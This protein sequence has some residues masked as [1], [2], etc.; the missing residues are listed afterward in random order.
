MQK[1]SIT[2]TSIVFD[3]AYQPAT[4]FLGLAPFLRMSIA[5]T[6]FTRLAEEMLAKA[7]CY[8]DDAELWMNLSTVMMCLKQQKVGLVIQEQAL[9]MQRVFRLPAARQPA[10]LRLLMLMVPGDLSANMPLDCLL[11][12][13]DV[14][15]LY[16]FITP[17]KPLAWPV[18][19]HDVV[20]VGI[21]AADETRATLAELERALAG[22]PKPIINAPQD[23]PAS[24]RYAASMLLQH[25]PG[26]TI[27][28]A[29]PIGRTTL[30]RIAAGEMRLKDSVEGHDF[31]IILRPIGSHGGRGLAKIDQCSAIGAYL[32]EVPAK[33]YFISRFVDYSGNDGLFRKFRIV[34]I[35][36]VPYA[37]HMAISSHWMIHYVNA[38]MYE[39]EKN[40]RKKRHFLRI[41]AISPSDTVTL[42]RRFTNAPI[43]IISAST[44][45]KHAT[46]ACW[47]LKSTPPWWCMPWIRKTS[48]HTSNIT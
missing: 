31:P 29:L 23:I 38:G 36:G 13:S 2:N 37:C 34:L 22:W 16:Y 27:C 3:A 41:S 8:P 40:A 15:L 11:E 20:I 39:D 46:D 32:A 47:F 48:F 30:E 35:A 4:L 26:L 5:G 43:S 28:P 7:E 14:D 44:A 25:A 10:K 9:A 21:S 42:W 33:A 6:D 24:E 45:R 12:N 18:P 17:G 19:D 1:L